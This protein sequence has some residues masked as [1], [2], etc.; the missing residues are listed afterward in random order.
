MLI[1]QGGRT[2]LHYAA[3]GGFSRFPQYNSLISILLQYQANP[4]EKDKVSLNLLC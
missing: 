1:P 2:P 4:N 3:F